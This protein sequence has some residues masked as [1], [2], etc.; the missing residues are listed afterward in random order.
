M[1]GSQKWNR[2]SAGG[3]ELHR[4][5][6]PLA[7]GWHGNGVVVAREARGVRGSL[8]GADAETGERRWKWWSE[9]QKMGD[10]GSETWPNQAGMD[11]GGGMTWLPGAYDPELNLI[12]WGT[13]NANP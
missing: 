12:F 2:D 10:P 3:R 4:Q 5:V 7:G 11:P 13:G 9:R 1:E 6:D 8:E